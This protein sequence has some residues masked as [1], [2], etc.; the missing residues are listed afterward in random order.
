M[1]RSRAPTGTPTRGAALPSADEIAELPA[2]GGPEFNRLIFEQSPYL[3]QHA[4]NPVDWY[5]W[6]DEAFAKAKQEDKAVFLSIGYS[7]CHWC[8]VMERESFEAQDVA[9][10]MNENFVCIKVDREERP[11]LDHVYMQVTQAM[12]GSGGWPMTVVMTPDKVPFFAGTY[13][14]REGRF[15]RPGM[16]EL[17]PQLGEAWRNDRARVLESAANVLEYLKKND[18]GNRVKSW[19]PM[20]WR[21]RNGSWPVASNRSTAASERPRSSPV[22]HNLL[23]LLQRYQREGKAQNLEM[24]EKTLVEMRQGGIWDHVG[25]GFHRYSTDAR[26]LVPH[27]EKMLYDQALQCMAYTAA[28]QVTREERYRRTAEEILTYVLR[29]MTSPDGG[30]YSAE[31]ADSEG[32]EGLFYLWTVDEVQAL[33]GPEEG[34]LF[35]AVFNLQ[36]EGNYHDEASG[37]KTKRNIPH[38]TKAWRALAA[39]LELE[40]DVLRGRMEAARVRLFEAREKRIHPLKDD[41]ILTDLEWADDRCARACIPGL[42]GA[43]LRRGRPARGRLRSLR[44]ALRRRPTLQA[45]TPG[46]GRPPGRHRRLRLSHVGALGAVRNRL[47]RALPRSRTRHDAHD[48]SALRGHGSGWFLSSGGRHVGPSGARQGRSTTALC[49]RA[50]R[51]PPGTY[52]GSVA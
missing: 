33:L 23:F 10:V 7:T 12:T 42:R 21:S 40:E 4:R 30:F 31:D 18:V 19:A 43:A 20:R 41:K 13:F 29:D 16:L 36:P 38:R 6:G 52:C 37:K 8:H 15:G 51:S 47:R 39:E 34:E 22:P 14:P 44:V 17:V 24:V 1:A 5:P 25:F 48:A 28:Y 2:D 11:A 3:L 50:R 32:E 49:H 46:P 9:A 27:F 26:W 45:L 35:T